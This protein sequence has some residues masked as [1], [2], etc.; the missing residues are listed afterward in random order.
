MIVDSAFSGKTLRLARD[1]VVKNGGSP[2]VL[3]IYPKSRS[4]FNIIDYA[5]IINKIYKVD[6]LE[7]DE[8]LFIKLY[9][10]NLRG[11]K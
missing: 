3:G 6:E 10:E 8:N 2:I 11:T 9:I 4:V 7:Y 1:Y 5:L